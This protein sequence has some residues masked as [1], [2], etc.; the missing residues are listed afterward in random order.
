MKGKGLTIL[1]IAIIFVVAFFGYIYMQN[2]KEIKISEQERIAEERRMEQERIAEERRMERERINQERKRK[3]LAF[4]E[5]VKDKL[6]DSKFDGGSNKSVKVK[7][8]EYFESDDSYRIEAS[9]NWNGDI[10]TSNYYAVDGYFTVKGDGSNPKW[11]T[12]WMNTEL[13]DY[14]NKKNF[15]GAAFATVIVLS[16]LDK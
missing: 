9:L 2:Q 3:A 1:V 6:I 10:N 4:A 12:T 5:Q 11:S 14:I 15:W 8:W 16:E 7:K 13:K